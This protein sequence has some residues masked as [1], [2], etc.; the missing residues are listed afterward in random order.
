MKKSSISLVVFGAYLVGTGTGLVFMPNTVLGILGLPPTDEVWIRVLGVVT[1]VLAYYYIQAARTNLR[2]FA[3]WTVPARILVFFF[4][5]GFVLAGW[6][7]P[8]MSALGAIDLVGALWTA[9]A[10]RK[11]KS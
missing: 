5:T 1:L 10:L 3:S 11:E 2:T 6:V 7:G 4:F 9:W 8:V